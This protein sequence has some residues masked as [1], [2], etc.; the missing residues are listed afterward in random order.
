MTQKLKT[1]S[2]AAAF[3]LF[4]SCMLVSIPQ[5]R[6]GE[7][8]A[9]D[10][11]PSVIL[12]GYSDAGTKFAV[13]FTPAQAC[14]VQAFQIAGGMG[15]GDI[16]LHVWRDNG[17]E[18]G[19]DL[20]TPVT[21]NLVG[22]L[23]YQTITLDNPVEVLG[24]DFHAGFEFTQN[25]PPYALSDDDGNT[26]DRSMV[27]EP[28][29]EWVVLD[30]D[31]AIRVYVEY[32]EPQMEE[33]IFYDGV[34]SY[35]L[36]DYT[37]AGDMFAVRFTNTRHPDLWCEI[38]GMRIATGGSGAGD[39]LVHVWSDDSGEPGTELIDPIEKTLSGLYTYE[40]VTPSNP[41]NIRAQDFHVG[42][43]LVNGS[44]PKATTDAEDPVENRSKAAHSD[45]VWEILDHNLNIQVYVRYYEP[46]PEL[47]SYDG[48][49]E[50]TLN[51]YTEANTKFAVKFTNTENPTFDLS[52]TALDIASQSGAGDV[53]LH[54]WAPGPD[55]MP[56]DDLITPQQVTLNGV[57]LYQTIELNE[58]VDICYE[59]FYA[60][61]ELISGSPPRATTDGNGVTGDRSMVKVGSDDWVILENDLNIR[62][63]V[64]FGEMTPVTVD[65]PTLVSPE[66]GGLV[67]NVPI[68]FEWN[69]VPNGDWYRIQVDDED[70][71]NSPDFDEIVPGT[72][73]S[74]SP[75]T[76]MTYYWR[77]ATFSCYLW[78]DWSAAWSFDLTSGV[79][80][81]DDST[82]P[83]EYALYQSYPN[84][85]NASTKITYA[86]PE[87][88]H[89]QVSIYNLTGQL[90]D[91]IVDE[92]QEAGYHTVDWNA[93]D[94]ST[95]IY[96]YKLN[97][98]DHTIAKRMTLLK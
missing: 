26:E 89:V 45:G 71:F 40:N 60:G 73:A 16:D 66:N 27:M 47:L 14:S 90:I 86:L 11:G 77:V 49:P 48:N 98:G 38:L 55:G 65:P 12:Y 21:Y 6:A 7:G 24:G 32:F 82:L 1:M 52:L 2:L 87:N 20:M 53:Y 70:Q 95:G 17:G 33:P 51:N 97:A 92:K 57:P 34:P 78:S 61:F 42:Y 54:I 23:Q 44:P 10:S 62:A 50:Y 91:T 58:A 8:L 69:A 96:F 30:N 31:L 19:D 36:N 84:P 15:T 75:V 74:W 68:D 29:G 94:Y 22:N 67:W 93:S 39:V 63:W 37:E 64:T 18:P 56:G 85:F 88:A 4:L 5:A 59:N 25:A 13:R 79:D 9:Y 43:E 46:G 80:D 3:L 72:T 28:G 81:I 76:P 35:M 83:T 41:I